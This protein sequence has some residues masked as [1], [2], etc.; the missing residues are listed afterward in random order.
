MAR[1]TDWHRV[2]VRPRLMV[3]ITGCLG[4]LL[5]PVLSGCSMPTTMHVSY[6]EDVHEYEPQ[7]QGT[8]FPVYHY[9]EEPD[10]SYTVI[11]KAFIFRKKTM[12]FAG[13][14]SE[15]ALLPI[16][17]RKASER[18]AEGLVQV[19][20]KP[21]IAW[22]WEGGWDRWVSGLMVRFE[23]D[24]PMPDLSDMRIAI[25][26]ILDENLER[27]EYS[28]YFNEIVELC[29]ERLGYIATFADSL[30]PLDYG[31][32]RVL[33]PDSLSQVGGEDCD[34]LLLTTIERTSEKKGVLQTTATTAIRV[35]L[36]SKAEGDVIWE[37][38]A[39]IATS[40][41]YIATAGVDD[42]RYALHHLLPDVV[43]AMPPY[44]GQVDIV[45]GR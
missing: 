36:I 3:L 4:A 1:N 38:E 35:R 12:R 10:S 44:K 28:H 24:G 33:D 17:I 22:R 11:G 8:T 42:R 37:Q 7:E 14:T 41:G 25:L 45:L 16:L 18:G 34:H 13:S 27:F 31:D 32:I 6:P 29:V 30:Q 19:R 20:S 43:S 21:N 40:L 23:E 26:P 2:I 5:L 9:G 39:D 15:E